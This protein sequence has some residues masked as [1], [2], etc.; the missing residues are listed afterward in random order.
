MSAAQITSLAYDSPADPKEL[1]SQSEAALFGVTEQTVNSSFKG[2]QELLVEANE[3][4]AEM[5]NREGMLQGVPTGF[6]DVDK[7]FAAC[8]R[9]TLSSWLLVL[10]LVKRRSL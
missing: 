7:L 1:I 4:I 9:A 2:I 3:E 6:I 5:G 8:V 10:L